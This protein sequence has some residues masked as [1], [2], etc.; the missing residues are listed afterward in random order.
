G[1]TSNSIIGEG[2]AGIAVDA[3]Q[4]VYVTGTTWSTNFPTMHA[5]P[6][7]TLTD[8]IAHVFVTKLHF[9]PGTGIL[10]IGRLSLVYSTYLGGTGIAVDA[11]SDAYV[12]G[13]TPST[14]FPTARPYQTL[15][16][17][18]V[19]VFVTKLHFDPGTSILS[20]VYSTY[21]GGT[22]FDY[23]TSIAVDANADVYVTG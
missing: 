13:Y 21:L 7:Q 8:G 6:Y 12:T 3:S 22:G 10:G 2:G 4:D 9:D 5:Y 15:T 17:A 14:N 11:N 23:G 18:I 1:G 19:H 16:D 20:L